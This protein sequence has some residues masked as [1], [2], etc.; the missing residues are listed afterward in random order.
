M[1]IALASTCCFQNQ[2]FFMKI[3][4]GSLFALPSLSWGMGKKRLGKSDSLACSVT[5]VRRM[6]VQV[7]QLLALIN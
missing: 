4:S 5:Q 2:I 1:L 7:M 6:V 3:R